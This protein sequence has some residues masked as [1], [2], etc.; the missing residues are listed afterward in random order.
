MLFHPHI[1]FNVERLNGDIGQPPVMVAID[2][3]V[4]GYGTA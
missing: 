4:G 1:S 3:P 2:M